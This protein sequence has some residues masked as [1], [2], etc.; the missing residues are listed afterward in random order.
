MLLYKRQQPMTVNALLAWEAITHGC[1]PAKRSAW[2]IGGRCNAGLL[3]HVVDDTTCFSVGGVVV[4]DKIW[5]HCQLQLKEKKTRGIITTLPLLLW[6]G[7]FGEELRLCSYNLYLI[8]IRVFFCQN[9]NS[10]LTYI[11]FGLYI[12]IETLN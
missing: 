11:K 1:Y 6:L 8:T 4:D 5:S 10:T 12:K 7:F 9:Y 3:P 2:S